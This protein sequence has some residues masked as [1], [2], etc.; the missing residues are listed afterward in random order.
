MQTTLHTDMHTL[1][2]QGV[3][4]EMMP[5][6]SSKVIQPYTKPVSQLFL[7]VAWLENN[8]WSGL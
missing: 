4:D 2:L 6:L 7:S 5:P 3:G 1:Y 8:S